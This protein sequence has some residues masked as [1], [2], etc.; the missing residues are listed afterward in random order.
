MP[1]FQLGWEFLSAAKVKDVLAPEESV[2]GSVDW[3]F[4]RDDGR[5]VSRGLKAVYR[6]ETAGGAA[7][8]VC[9][10]EGG[11]GGWVCG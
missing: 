3:L 6:V 10:K 5:G 1:T 4:L 11:V 2:E 9:E 8:G 7:P